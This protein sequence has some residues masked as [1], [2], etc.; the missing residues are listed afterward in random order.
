VQQVLQDKEPEVSTITFDLFPNP[1]NDGFVLKLHNSHTG[2]VNVQV[3]N[4]SGIVVSRL[5]FA[6]ASQRSQQYISV[7]GLAAGS[8][9]VK[10]E[11]DGWQA[12][13][14]FTKL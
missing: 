7:A 9:F 6:K 1:A 12:A 13:K 14:R 10:V 4:A 2:T 5:Q 8:Y 3:I 11:M